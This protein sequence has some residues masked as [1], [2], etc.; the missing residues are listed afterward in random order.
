MVAVTSRANR[1]FQHAVRSAAEQLV[2][3]ANPLERESVRELSSV[4]VKLLAQNHPPSFF[5]V[6]SKL[7]C[8]VFIASEMSDLD[9]LIN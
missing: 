4:I 5:R 2:G 6:V 1:Y 3:I 9:F 8:P 7:K